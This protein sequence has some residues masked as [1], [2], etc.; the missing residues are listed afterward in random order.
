MDEADRAQE[1]MEKEEAMR[2]RARTTYVPRL[3]CRTCDDP[4]PPH[5]RPYGQCMDCAQEEE[6]T[7]KLYARRG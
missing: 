2:T 6:H 1:A 5:R 3:T 7:N 4:L